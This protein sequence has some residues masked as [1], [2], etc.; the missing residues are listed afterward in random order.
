MN[1]SDYKNQKNF[2]AGQDILLKVASGVF[3]GTLA[4]AISEKLNITGMNKAAISTGGAVA[5]VKILDNHLQD[6]KQ[7]ERELYGDKYYIYPNLFYIVYETKLKSK[8]K[9]ILELF[10]RTGYP[11]RAKVTQAMSQ[12][13]PGQYQIQSVQGRFLLSNYPERYEVNKNF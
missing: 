1:Y 2:S 10:D 3:G 9:K 7:R 4:N 5:G 11:D 8:N 6:K 12:M 13:D